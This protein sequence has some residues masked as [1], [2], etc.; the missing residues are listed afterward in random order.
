MGSSLAGVLD[1]LYIEVIGEV[2]DTT[3][4]SSDMLIRGRDDPRGK[5]ANIEVCAD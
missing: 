1:I 2:L 3:K 5:E 4:R